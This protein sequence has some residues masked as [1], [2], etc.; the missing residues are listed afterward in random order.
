MDNWNNSANIRVYNW[1]SV[2]NREKPFL[3]ISVAGWGAHRAHPRGDTS[4]HLTRIFYLKKIISAPGCTRTSLA[5]NKYS[6]FFAVQKR[7]T[8]TTY[9][10]TLF[11]VDDRNGTFCCHLSKEHSLSSSFKFHCPINITVFYMW[12]SLFCSCCYAA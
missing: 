7:T 10:S 5:L 12:Y 2:S 9:K 8:L 11:P 1:C 6:H 4:I 3:C